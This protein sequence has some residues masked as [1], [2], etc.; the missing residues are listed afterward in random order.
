MSEPSIVWMH[1]KCGH[2]AVLCDEIPAKFSIV[3]PQV[4]YHLSG[5]KYEKDR[6]FCDFCRDRMRHITTTMELL[7]PE[8]MRAILDFNNN[9]GEIKC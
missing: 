8:T 3:N 9:R 5:D 2:P 4:F 7:T 6:L 1:E